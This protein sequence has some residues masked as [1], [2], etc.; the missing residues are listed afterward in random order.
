[1]AA[2]PDDHHS[3]H[4]A[5][6]MSPLAARRTIVLFSLV[7]T[8]ILIPFLI[9]APY[10]GYP[11]KASESLAVVRIVTPVFLGFLG[12]ASIFVTKAHQEIIRPRGESGSLIG[13]LIFGPFLLFFVSMV[14]SPH[15]TA[16]NG[17]TVDELTSWISIVLGILTVTV[18]VI[19]NSL[20]GVDQRESPVDQRDSP[21]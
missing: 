11:L 6:L 5:A 9:L 4:F 12:A 21:K 2:E 16:G 15:A 19:S 20:F 7:S 8:G 17:M 3:R 13:Y 1:M 14:S 10:V 18:G